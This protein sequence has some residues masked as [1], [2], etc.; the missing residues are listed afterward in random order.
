VL[1]ADTLCQAKKRDAEKLG[2]IKRFL[3]EKLEKE[4][5]NKKVEIAN[6]YWRILII[7]WPLFFRTTE[8]SFEILNLILKHSIS[9]LYTSPQPI[10]YPAFTKD[11]KEERKPKVP[12]SNFYAKLLL[13]PLSPI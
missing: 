10:T 1:V 11:G 12:A 4:L 7:G 8:D 9:P 5:A 13:Q 2:E 3:I 6:S